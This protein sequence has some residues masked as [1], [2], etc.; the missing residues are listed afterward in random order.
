M[1]N[2]S[3]RLFSIGLLILVA[4]LALVGCGGSTPTA[5]ADPLAHLEAGRAHLLAGDV[6]KA[7]A[8]FGAAVQ[9]DPTLAEAHFRLGNAYAEL[10]QLDKAAEEFKAVLGLNANDAEAHSNL[11]VV[12][13]QQ[14]KLSE[15]VSEF[16]AALEISPKDAEVHYLLGAAYVQMGR[17]DEAVKEFQ[18]ALEYDPDLPEAYFG[19][20]TVYKLQGNKEEAEQSGV[21]HF[22]EHMLFKGTEKRPTAMDIAVAIEGIGGIFNAATGTE[23]SVYWIKV[24]QPHLDIAIDVLVDMLRHSRFDPQEIDRERRVII[25]EINL[26]HDTPDSLIHLLI[27]ELV[28]P[29]HPLGRDVAGTKESLSALDREGL[30]A[31]FWMIGPRARMLPIGQPRIIR[32]SRV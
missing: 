5:P 16:Q 6:E 24:A 9:A 25:E 32:P 21:S 7:I 13:Y 11:G 15:A 28:W 3:I 20:G 19:L 14:G 2:S 1:K 30:L 17:I 22:I 23:S 10:G 27:N 18:T 8:E 29:D 31:L 4:T 12:Y 26:T